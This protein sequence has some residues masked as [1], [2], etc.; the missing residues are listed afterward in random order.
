M[1][2]QI[3]ITL[4]VSTLVS[5]VVLLARTFSNPVNVQTVYTGR[6]GVAVAD[7]VM[8]TTGLVTLNA[9]VLAIGRARG[10]LG[11]Q[12]PF[13]IWLLSL[14]GF[15]VLFGIGDVYATRKLRQSERLT[16]LL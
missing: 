3:S 5:G 9:G 7:S 12:A 8:V 11:S 1:L 4:S 13:R 16:M 6:I 10:G 14:L 2:K 15:L